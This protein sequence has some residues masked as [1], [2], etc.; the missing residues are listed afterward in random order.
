MNTIFYFSGTGNSKIAALELSK[1][2]A[3]TQIVSLTESS[4]ELKKPSSR[5]VGFV[6]PIHSLGLPRM[7]IK[8]IESMNF[9]KV[10]YIYAIAA[11]GGGYGIA[12]EQINRILKK[13]DKLL[14]ATFAYSFGSNSN[15]FIKIPGTN[16]VLPLEEQELRYQ[17]LIQDIEKTA[18]IIQSKGTSHVDEISFTFRMLS[19]MAHSAFLKTLPKFDK[20]FQ[21]KNCN[22]C[23]ICSRNCPV[24]NIQIDKEGPAWQG[25][26]EA[27]LRCFNICPQEAILFGKM[28][29][30]RMVEKYTRNLDAIKAEA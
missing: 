26:C 30:P 15:L 11:M 8:T 21:T 14:S 28:D 9:E 7:L 19:K 20:Q 5:C 16:P 23:G 29:D 18:Q 22:Q 13:K 24:H 4:M 12:F 1:H 25:N 27:C 3:D 6:F 17:K 10:D 2:I